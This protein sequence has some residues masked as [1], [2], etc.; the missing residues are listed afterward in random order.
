LCRAQPGR[1]EHHGHAAENWHG[2]GRAC[3]RLRR[4]DEAQD[5][6]SRAVGHQR[7]FVEKAP[8]D[9]AAAKNL[10]VFEKDLARAQ[11]RA[12]ESRRDEGKPVTGR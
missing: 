4:W 1:E 9:D 5:A 6:W 8:R 2:L 11:S 10:R 7:A 3:F 12:A